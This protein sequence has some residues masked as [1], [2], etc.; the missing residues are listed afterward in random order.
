MKIRRF[1]FWPH[2]VAGC[3]AG[4]V[5][6]IMSVTGMLLAYERQ[7][8]SWVNREDRLVAPSSASPLSLDD[9]VG[10]YVESTGAVPTGITLRSDPT[11]AVEMNFGREQAVYLNPY[12]GSKQGESSQTAR[13][14]FERVT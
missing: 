11:A 3:L 1:V 10:R 2:L 5:I 6:L 13:V 8:L 7:I 9:I 12:S 4:T 14:F